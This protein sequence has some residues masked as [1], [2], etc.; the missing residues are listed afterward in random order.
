[1]K[2]GEED[3]EGVDDEGDDV[4]EGSERERHLLLRLQV[5]KAPIWFDI[6]SKK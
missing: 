4:S 5:E 3:K 1:M 6:N 2:D